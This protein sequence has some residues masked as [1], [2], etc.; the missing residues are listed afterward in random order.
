MTDD[1]IDTNKFAKRLAR[2]EISIINDS[3]LSERNK[4]II[5]NYIRDSKLGKVVRKGQK[6]KIGAGRNLQTASYLTRMAKDW[7]KKNLDKV[8]HK[9][10]ET[11][12]LN[13]ENGVILSKFGTPMKSETQC[14]IKKFLR[15]FYKHLY[16]EGKFV[17]DIV[18]WIDTSKQIAKISAV[19]GLKTGIDR[20]VALIPNFMKK[21]L[22]S[23]SFD[24]GF[25]S[26]ELL[27]VRMKDVEKRSDGIYYLT[28]RYS[29]TKPRTVSI[30]LASNE[31][32]RWLN[33]HPD[34]DNPQAQLFPLSKVA[35]TKTIN[36]YGRKALQTH[37]TPHMLRHTSATYYASRL[38][39]SSFCKRFGWSYSSTSPDRYIDFSKIEEDKVIDIIKKDQNME[40]S[41]ELEQL[42]VRNQ[43]LQDQ[44]EMMKKQEERIK[45]MEALMM[46]KFADEFSK[47]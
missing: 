18:E 8:T 27:N 13:L 5:L 2:K 20:L 46:Q 24:S 35:F 14:N 39:R 19:P 32:S 16:G 17:P 22:I 41:N 42:K 11:F 44:L 29:K 30:P 33:E 38:D 37:I 25:R 6:R 3:K 7:F 23:V 36:S 15:K 40:L 26:D 31:L 28:C 10:V 47:T 21:A 1:Y 4:E 12:I 43:A 9:D 34:K 45:Q